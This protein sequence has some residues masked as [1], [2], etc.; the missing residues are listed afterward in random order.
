M[1]LSD[2]RARLIGRLRQRKTREREGLLLVEGIRAAGEALAASARTKFAVV[3]PRLDELA[4]GPAL[5]ERLRGSGIEVVEADD[6][7]L[8]A[9]ADTA[10]HQGVL[11][12][13]PEPPVALAMPAT[14]PLLVLDGIQDPGNVGTLI[15]AAAAFGAREVIA[16][17]GTVDPY[18]AKAVRAAAGAI[19]A[20]GVRRSRWSEVAVELGARGPLVVADMGGEDVGTVRVPATWSLVVGGEGAGVRPEVHAAAARVVSIPMPGGVESLNA[21]VAGSILLYILTREDRGG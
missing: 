19:F 5:R 8:G 21:G 3:S 2:E 16:L 4:G 1:A 14:G 10:A 20:V 13:C 6:G 9:V 17:D 12:V 15:R 7:E 11:L 18:N